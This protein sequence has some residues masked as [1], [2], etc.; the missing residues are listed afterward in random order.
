MVQNRWSTSHWCIKII[1]FYWASTSYSAVGIQL[2][3]KASVPSA[4]CNIFLSYYFR[5]AMWICVFPSRSL[6]TFGIVTWETGHVALWV[7]LYPVVFQGTLSL[8]WSNVN[9]FSNKDDKNCYIMFTIGTTC[10]MF[11]LL[12]KAAIKPSICHFKVLI[13]L[14]SQKVL[15]EWAKNCIQLDAFI[16]EGSRILMFFENSYIINQEFYLLKLG[17]SDRTF[18]FVTIYRMKLSGQVFKWS[19]YSSPFI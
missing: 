11:P 10:Y 16:N 12:N 7:A 19:I 9:S 14:V 1:V 15:N 3:S 2:S 18:H 6:N 5:E 13:N 4:S 8:L 17:V